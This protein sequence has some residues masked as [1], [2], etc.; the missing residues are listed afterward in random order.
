MLRESRIWVVAVS[1]S[2][3]ASIDLLNAVR[4]HVCMIS[5]L[6]LDA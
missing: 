6:R 4:H 3:Y 1:D 2:S 5:R